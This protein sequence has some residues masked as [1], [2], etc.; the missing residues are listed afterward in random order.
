MRPHRISTLS[1]SALT[2]MGCT[3]AVR[4]AY[5]PPPPP[6]AVAVTVAAPAPAEPEPPAEQ[7][8]PP[9]A[10]A[11]APAADDTQAQADTYDDQDPT[12]LQDFHPALDAHGQWVDDPVYGTVWVPNAAEVGPDFVP[13]IGA[14]H[15]V[16]GDDY[17]WVSDYDWGWAPFHYGRWVPLASGSWGWIPG[18]EYA[19]AWVEWRVGDD[20][21]GWAPAAPAF[22]WRGGVVLTVGFA[23]PEPRYAFVAHADLFAPAP[24]RVV[25]RGERA[26]AIRGRTHVYAEGGGG[27]GHGRHGPPPTS[28]KIPPSKVAHATGHER[29][30]E[31]AR[32]FGHPSTA[33]RLG[34]HPPAKRVAAAGPGARP[35]RAQARPGEEHREPGRTSER[36][37]GKTSER[38]PAKGSERE[39]AKGA[40]REPA[41]ATE[42]EPAKTAGSE[43]GRTADEHASNRAQAGNE[44]ARTGESA[45][46]NESARSTGSEASRPQSATASAHAPAAQPQKAPA[47]RA[48]PP[49]SAPSPKKK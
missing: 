44:S 48:A 39:P 28:L 32:N 30:A 19:P 24:G 40:E 3:V 45:R 13:Y 22:I 15:W 1:L 36:E 12:A 16:Y 43:P 8:P 20:Y 7:P 35:G 21:V 29:G 23:A 38:E 6:P 49:K 46:T 17:L 41:K 42:H 47:P 5:V 14:G 25:I 4:P 11:A 34:A 37:P 2:C 27:A 26:E 10:P 31:Q 33:Q 18:R 9:E